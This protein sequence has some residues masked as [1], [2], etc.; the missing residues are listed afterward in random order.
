MSTST[1]ISRFW[2]SHFVTNRLT[3]DDLPWG[4]T[5]QLTSRERR[6]IQRSI[7]QFQLGEGSSGKRLLKRGL[8]QARATRD[9]DFLRALYLFVKEEQRHSSY[10]LRFM[11]AQKMPTLRHQW[12]D[13]VF[14]VLRGL[15]GLELSLRVLVTAEIVAVPY[16]RALRDATSSPLL[17]AMSARILVDEA[18]HLRFQ[19]SMLSRLALRRWASTDALIARTHRLFL[20]GT[21]LIVWLGHRSVFLAAAYTLRKLLLE[22]HTELRLLACETARS[23]L[24]ALGT[25]TEASVEP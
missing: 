4:D 23:R 25:T 21:S 8:A 9:P 20:T 12:V 5:Y 1:K 16:Y 24:P 15:A 17:K 13:S 11:Q 6:A 2:S 10:L 14:R 3:S 22:A 18:A 7:Q 19:A